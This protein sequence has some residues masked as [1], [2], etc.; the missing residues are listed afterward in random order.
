[1]VEQNKGLV[2]EIAVLRA[3]LGFDGEQDEKEQQKQ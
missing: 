3:V 1:L 2:A